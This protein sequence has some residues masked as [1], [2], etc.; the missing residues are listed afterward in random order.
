MDPVGSLIYMVTKKNPVSTPTPPGFRI[1]LSYT[2]TRIHKCCHTFLLNENAKSHRSAK[3]TKNSAFS[4]YFAEHGLPLAFMVRVGY[5]FS[6]LLSF[7]YY[8]Y[9]S[10]YTL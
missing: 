7:S 4:A 1:N 8:K 9:N 5:N 10:I 2:L 3:R 6:G